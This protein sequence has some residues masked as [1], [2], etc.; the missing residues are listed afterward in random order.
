M[1][2]SLERWQLT[3][4]FDPKA[5]Q[6][7]VGLELGYEHEQFVTWLETQWGALP[8]EFAE[9]VKTTTLE[10]GVIQVVAQS[11]IIDALMGAQQWLGWHAVPQRVELKRNDP[12][13]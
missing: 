13:I 4:D 6:E 12:R 5:I 3:V 7:E 2:Q 9:D 10:S 8:E 11:P 1:E